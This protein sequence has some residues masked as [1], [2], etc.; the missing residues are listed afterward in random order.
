VPTG[1]EGIP[2]PGSVAMT[3]VTASLVLHA[4]YTWALRALIIQT[5]EKGATTVPLGDLVVTRDSLDVI[6]PDFK[7]NGWQLHLGDGCVFLL[8]L[9]PTRL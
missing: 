2:S 8:P 3:A 6:E 4:K 7:A 5:L 9:G 1:S